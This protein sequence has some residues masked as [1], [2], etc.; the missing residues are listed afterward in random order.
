[1][2]NCIT[3]G[4]SDATRVVGLPGKYNEW[5]QVQGNDFNDSS[6]NLKEFDPDSTKKLLEVKRC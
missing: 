1:M 2:E 6:W 3:D 5:R 4:A